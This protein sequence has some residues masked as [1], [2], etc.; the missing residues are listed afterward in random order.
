MFRSQVREVITSLDTNPI[1]LQIVLHA[2]HN[3][4]LLT[5]G[6]DP[7]QDTLKPQHLPQENSRSWDGEGCPRSSSQ[8]QSSCC[9]ECSGS[10]GVG[11]EDWGS[12][13]SQE[14]AAHGC[15]KQALGTY[16][17]LRGWCY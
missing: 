6:Q 2:L 5:A 9:G 8:D 4:P 3:L 16:Y 15:H 10:E 1:L 17:W 11:E 7:K 14:E 12:R 13:S